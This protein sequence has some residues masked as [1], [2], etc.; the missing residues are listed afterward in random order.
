MPNSKREDFKKKYLSSIGKNVLN[1]DNFKKKYS[2]ALS[3]QHYHNI[4]SY[5]VFAETEKDYSPSPEA[6]K[7]SLDQ[8]PSFQSIIQIEKMNNKTERDLKKFI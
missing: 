2:S 4:G 7:E 8:D 1:A 5:S 6:L 3:K